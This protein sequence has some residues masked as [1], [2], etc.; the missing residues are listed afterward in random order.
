VI[1]VKEESV[2]H[3]PDARSVLLEKSGEEP[4]VTEE[5]DPPWLR[6]IA[7]W[8]ICSLASGILPGQALFVKLFAEAGIYG[9]VCHHH[10]HEGEPGCKDQFLVLTGLFQT[11]AGLAAG[12][13]APIGLFFDRWGAQLVGTVGTATCAVGLLFIWGSAVGAAHGLDSSTSYLFVIGVITSDFGSMLNSFSFMGLIWHFPGRQARVLA[14]INATYQISAFLPVVMQAVMDATGVPMSDILLIW[15]LA[16]A[17]LVCPSWFL[18]PAQT[19]YYD[20][21]KKVL[22][23]PLPRPPKEIKPFEMMSRAWNVLQQNPCEHFCCGAALSFGYAL[24]SFYISM[25]AAYG[26]ALFGH[27]KDGERLA[28]V[29]VLATGIVGLA[30]GPFAGGIADRFGLPAFILFLAFLLLTSGSTLCLRSWPAQ[31]VCAGCMVLFNLL[32]NLFISKYLLMY[33]PPNRFGTV[34]GVFT[35]VVVLAALPWSM[36]G[37][38]VTAVLPQGVDAYRIPMLVFAITGTIAMAMYAWY[39]LRNPAPEVPILLPDDEVDLAKGFGC[40]T[41]EE[42]MEVTHISTRKELIKMLASSDP[43]VSRKL[44][45]SIDT[46]KMMEM[47]SRRS[48]DD[49]AEMMEDAGDAE[50]DEEEEEE[51]ASPTLPSSEAAAV[52]PQVEGGAIEEPPSGAASAEVLKEEDRIRARGRSLSEIVAA[53]DKEALKRYMLEE[54]VD[55]MWSTTL[56]M[57]DWQTPEERKK[58]DKDFNKLLPAKEFA[59]LLR[60]RPELK[61]IVQQAMKREMERRIAS[62]R[63][64]KKSARRTV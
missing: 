63:G 22:G 52:A 37:M 1:H 26:Q 62:F 13:L 14:L 24:P 32:F 30:M 39:Y 43:D 45:K 3:E 53:N 29:C 6:F 50:E 57:E 18:I 46:E 58:M 48:V 7:L 9:S 34:Q 28:E 61:K 11:G 35:L 42:V 36:S 27:E 2:K 38:G 12:F 49:I 64:K 55:D 56:D 17:I 20:Q 23:M 5:D 59:A 47:M 10:G 54:P 8:L 51:P 16:I 4:E 21:A 31:I 44:I 33:S 41:L 19:E 25:A 15:A 40:S 60:Q